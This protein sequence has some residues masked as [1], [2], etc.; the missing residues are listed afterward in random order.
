MLDGA[1]TKGVNET[2]AIEAQSCAQ[3][4]TQASARDHCAGRM[5]VTIQVACM[6]TMN[7]VS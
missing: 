3:T 5:P 4:K 6:K 1:H 7:G 2:D